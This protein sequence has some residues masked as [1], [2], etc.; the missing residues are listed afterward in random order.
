V[1]INKTRLFPVMSA[2][3]KMERDLATMHPT[4]DLVISFTEDTQR[5]YKIT[6][7]DWGRFLGTLDSNACLARL[8]V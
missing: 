4:L 8:S 1:V 5:A 2:N 3:V 6:S 7:V